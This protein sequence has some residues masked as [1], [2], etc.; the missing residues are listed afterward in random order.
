MIG[1]VKLGLLG[2]IVGVLATGCAQK[3]RIKALNPAEVGAM[4][5][6]KKVAVSKFKNDRVGLSGKIEAQIAKQKLDKKRYFTV[7]SR[8]DMNKVM[9]EQKLQSS[10]LM[11]EATTAKVGKLIG[12][13]AIIN[14]EVTSANAESDSYMEDREKCL[15]YSKTGCVKYRYYKVKCNTTQADV[16]ANIAIINVENAAVIYGDTINKTY[17]ADSCKMS[18]DS[19]LGVGLSLLGV[20][21]TPK[22]ILSKS[23]ALS[24]LAGDIASE[25]V[26]KL[27]PNYI[28]F[29]VVLLDKIEIDATSEQ[30]KKFES[31]LAYIKAARYD[32]A[33]KI[34]EDLM[35]QLDGKSYVV[36]YVYGVVDEATGNFEKAKELYT[37][38]DDLALEPVGEINLAMTRID[39]L[40]EKRDEAKKQMNE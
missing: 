36:A 22:Q 2:V 15:K 32:K 18:S 34:L 28:Y 12:A 6:K 1:I 37:I 5:S 30:E 8:K 25:F 24:K 23:Q 26:Y 39:A 29:N 21:T 9:A 14:G 27:T 35:N 16:S 13:Q 33:K 11:D 38:A 4:A 3:V 7:L 31:A 19:V 40:I 20:N 17:S 10:E